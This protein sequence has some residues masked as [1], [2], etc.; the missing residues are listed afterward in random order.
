MRNGRSITAVSK[1]QDAELKPSISLFP[2]VSLIEREDASSKRGQV[3][4]EMA[5]VAYPFEINAT[6]T[7]VKVEA[8]GR[9][10]ATLAN[11]RSQ[12]ASQALLKRL[13]NK[14]LAPSDVPKFRPGE[15]SYA[16]DDLQ[17]PNSQTIKLGPG[18]VEIPQ[19][20]VFESFQ[21]VWV[22]PGTHL[23]MGKDASLIFLGRVTFAGQLNQVITIE[24]MNGESWGGIA[25]QG[26][27]TA[28][29]RIEHVNLRGGT[30]PKWRLIPYPGM[31]NV[32]NTED[33]T[34]RNCRFADNQNS[35][36]MF[37]AAYVQKLNINNVHTENAFSD[38]WDL[39]FTQ[40]SMKRVHVFHS[41]DEAIDLMTS[42]IY[43]SD[44]ILV[45]SGGNCI[46]AGE[47]SQVI[48]RGSLLAKS[49]VGLLAKNAS[50]VDISNSLLYRNRTGVEVY[51]RTVR[52]AGESRVQADVL[53]IVK[54]E[55][56]LKRKTQDTHGLDLRRL[57]S[58]LPRR[59]SGELDHL[60]NNVLEL[61]TWV[62]LD[63]WLNGKDHGGQ[64]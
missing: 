21:S 39:E 63:T 2:A 60:R 22:A 47:N 3:R 13:P 29:S 12:P 56:T 20:K 58:R 48:I 45:D 40:A 42:D 27:N 37:H 19:T 34:V 33:I 43:I 62:E 57:Q 11:V 49:K 5:A 50:T 6:C 59:G 32:H 51:K 8:H 18:V 1:L 64:K 30:A 36:D 52:Y 28:G 25:L 17:T 31:F 41:Q 23:R 35:D 7:P 54:S 24:G 46:S 53:F 10:L 38:A 9:H 55:K 44:S 26:Y 14:S 4:T 16:V 61:D 15:V